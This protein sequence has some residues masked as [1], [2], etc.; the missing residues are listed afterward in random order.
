MDVHDKETRSF[1]MRRISSK[2]TSIELIVRKFLFRNGF[3]YSLKNKKIPGNPDIAFP[4]HKIAIFLNGC[5]FHNHKG[6]ALVKIIKTNED[7]WKNKIQS[8]VTRDIK[9]SKQLENQ[10]WKVIILWECELEPRKKTSP[11]REFALEKLLTGILQ[12]IRS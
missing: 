7:F 1:N 5:F 12:I 8:N 4:K 10:G 11:K 2:N 3:R 9:N 6:C